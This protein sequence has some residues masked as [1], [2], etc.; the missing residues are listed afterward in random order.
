MI[1]YALHPGFIRSVNDGD[2]HFI[3]A[4]RLAYLYELQPR[5]WIDW[6]ARSIPRTDWQHY[7]HLGPCVHYEDYKVQA[8][9][10]AARRQ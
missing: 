1:V 3:S 7:K 9:K 6:S 10:I 5:E 8:R 2:L 4:G